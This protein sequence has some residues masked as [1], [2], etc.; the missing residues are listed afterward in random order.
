MPHFLGRND[1]KNSINRSFRIFR[2][3]LVVAM[4]GLVLSGSVAAEDWPQWR[5]PDRNGISRESGLMDSWP[6]GG[7]PP[8]WSVSKRLKA[9][10]EEVGAEP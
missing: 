8:E 4:A 9:C 7:P 10:A 2:F 5:G 1:V 6:G 3:P